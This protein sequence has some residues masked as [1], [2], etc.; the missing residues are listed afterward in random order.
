MAEEIL[1]QLFEVIKDRKKNLPENS[2]T[3]RLFKKGENEIGKKIGE[4][5]AELL[6]AMVKKDPQ[7]IIY[8]TADLWYHILVMLSF[9]DIELSEILEEL[10]KRFG[11]SGLEE[12]AKRGKDD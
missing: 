3:T 1:F 6:M 5:G 10:K 7:A 12:K 8:E 9:Y 4:E 2:Y 11:L